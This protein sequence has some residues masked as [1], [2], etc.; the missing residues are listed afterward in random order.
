MKGYAFRES[1]FL[2]FV[3]FVGYAG[4]S[5]PTL[6]SIITG[7][8]KLMAPFYNYVITSLTLAFSMGLT[9][10]ASLRLSY[11][12]SVLFKSSKLIPVMIGNIIFLKKKPKITE[13]ASVVLMVI[14]LIGISLGDFRGKNKFD[15]PGII[16]VSLS[17]VF[18]AVA[19]NME[20]KVMSVYGASQ[21]EVISMLYSLGALI[22]GVMSLF[23]GQMLQG[24]ERMVEQPSSIIYVIFFSCLGA[25]GIQFVYLNMKVFG[26]LLT[27]MV[28]SLRKAFT[29]ILSFLI[30]KDK[31]F[32]SLHAIA[33][34]L[35]A[36]GI[37]INI[38]DKAT[39]KKKVS[40][41]EMS[42]LD[43]VEKRSFTNKANNSLVI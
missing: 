9:N 21:G 33:I 23:T 17:L 6:L 10:F 36:T 4:L 31:K 14:G 30:F 43:N 41:E 19:S 28:T 24:C 38:H 5:F 1:I 7:K 2:T 25:V 40:E 22:M 37:A 20:D 13:A 12:T 34:F 15:L 18:G 26:S 35:I 42:L 3:Q 32:T 27:V 29:V 16:T 39:S 11:A 8:T